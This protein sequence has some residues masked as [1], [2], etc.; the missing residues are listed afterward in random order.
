MFITCSRKADVFLKSFTKKLS[1]MFPNVKYV[2]RGQTNI[3]KLF[4]K[5]LYLGHKNFLKTTNTKTEK[6]IFL[7]HYLQ[8][9][10]SF[11]LHKTYTIEPINTNINIS[12][13]SLKSLKDVKKPNHLFCFL[14]DCYEEDAS[15]EII[16]TKNNIYFKYNNQDVDFS[17]K[18]VNKK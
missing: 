10:N 1:L 14:N 6:T 17:F 11:H 13:L 8:Q 2:P 4:K 3:N 16:D 5:A 18:I 9:N 7:E 12:V 15:L